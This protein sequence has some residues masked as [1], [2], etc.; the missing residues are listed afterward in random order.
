MLTGCIDLLSL[1]K[2]SLKVFFN[3]FPKSAPH[4]Q[5]HCGTKFLVQSSY[6]SPG[7]FS[8]EMIPSSLAPPRHHFHKEN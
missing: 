1:M 8:T 7:M 2:K 6:K 3:L 5:Q 4:G